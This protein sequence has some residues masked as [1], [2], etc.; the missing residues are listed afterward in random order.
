MPC[1]VAQALEVVGERWTL[2]VVRDCLL[3]VTRFDQIQ[4]RLGIARNVLSDRLDL[5][6][7]VEVLERRPYQERPVRHEYVLTER[8]RDLWPVVQAL[9]QWGDRW[10]DWPDGP[11]VQQV[12]EPCGRPATVVPTCSACRGVL[13][14]EDLRPTSGGHARNVLPTP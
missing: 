2:L 1:S 13:H 4:Q 12:H 7:E 10:A 8:G 3:G 11:P 14:P 9:Q 5:L 6:V